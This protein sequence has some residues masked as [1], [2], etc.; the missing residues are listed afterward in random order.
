[1]DRRRRGPPEHDWIRR[2]AVVLRESNRLRAGSDVRIRRL[3]D[4]PHPL[5]SGGVAHRF[6]AARLDRRPHCKACRPVQLLGSGVDWFA[7]MTAQIVAM[8]WWIS[9]QPSILPWIA[10]ATGIE[11]CNSLFD[12]ATTATGRYPKAPA[13]LRDRHAFF[14]ILDWSMPGGSYT[15]FGNALWLAYP[16]CILAFCLRLKTA[17]LVLL[18]PAVLYLWCELAWTVFILA[19][20]AEPVRETVVYEDGPEGND[21]NQARALLKKF[22]MPFKSA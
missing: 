11:L 7:D 1:M 13:R 12:F 8:G 18:A 3:S 22:R 19:N 2:G 6:H 5:V 9:V 10:A 14:A 17:G 4:R 16:L 20:W 21:D 15:A